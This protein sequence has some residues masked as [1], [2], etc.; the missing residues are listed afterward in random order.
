MEKCFFAV[1]QRVFFTSYP[2]VPAMKKDVL[3][4]LLLSTAVYN[5]SCHLD[6]RRD[7]TI[8]PRRFGAAVLAPAIVVVCRFLIGKIL[9]RVR[10]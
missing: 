8:W 5:F 1:E 3:P 4:A 10:I 7:G 9:K 2:L 6:S